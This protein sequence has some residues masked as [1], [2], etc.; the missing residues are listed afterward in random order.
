MLMCSGVRT[1][2]AATPQATP[3][4]SDAQPREPDEIDTLYEAGKAA[5]SDGEAALALGQFKAALH[6]ASGKEH[7][8]WPLLLAVALA[9]KQTDAPGHAMEYFR[10]FLALTDTHQG[11]LTLK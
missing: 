3:L 2:S 7:R 4:K 9:Y 5:L 1:A 10:R 8:T 11:S 6:L